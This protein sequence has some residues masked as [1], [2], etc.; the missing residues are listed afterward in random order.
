M[1]AYGEEVG[2]IVGYQGRDLFWMQLR[3]AG[4][5]GRFRAG[6]ETPTER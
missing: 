5:E 4:G 6:R 2:R 1:L 3:A